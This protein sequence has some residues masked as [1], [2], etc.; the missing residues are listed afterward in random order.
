[1]HRRVAGFLYRDRVLA[2]CRRHVYHAGIRPGFVDGLGHGVK[3]GQVEMTGTTLAGCY[4]PNH[5]GTV[6]NSLLTMQSSLGTGKTLANNFCV[7]IDK[8]THD[9]ST[10]P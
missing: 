1:M 10:L 7:F 8:D 9:Y 4:T 5:P 6:G 3:D 2:E